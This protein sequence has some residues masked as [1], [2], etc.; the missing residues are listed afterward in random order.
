MSDQN[1]SNFEAFGAGIMGFVAVMAVGGGALLVHNS[2]QPKAVAAAA[3]IDI[4][5]P[6]SRPVENIAVAA[7]E[8]RADSPAPLI[9]AET[10]SEAVQESAAGG[11]ASAASVSVPGASAPAA[12]AG[13][14]K[15]EI[16]QHLD[17][18]GSGTTAVA[19]VK[20]TAV[21][22]K[23]AKTAKAAD[24]KAVPKLNTTIG[25]GGTNAVASVHYGVTSRNELMGR[26]VG[27]VLNVKGG[28]KIGGGA[29]AS[30]KMAGDASA[31][32]ANLQKQ[33]D[34]A[35]LPADQRARIQKN[36]AQA[37][38]EIDGAEKTAQ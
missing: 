34:A 28:G 16:A 5:S 10:S 7:K 25:P 22:A 17:A 26:A 35:G 18:T 29:A 37:R 33:L 13:D 1:K 20:N 14:P 6:I 32:I 15:L 9:G 30:S 8:R 12:G 19:S 23:N 31:K 11:A 4:A 27:S 3:P 21:A 2:Q 36:M 38:A 24:K